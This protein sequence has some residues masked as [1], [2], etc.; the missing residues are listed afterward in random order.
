[1]TKPDAIAAIDIG[2]DT[3]HLLIGSVADSEDGPLVNCI[4]QEGQLLLLGDRAAV[5]G[6][7]H[8]R[9]DRQWVRSGWPLHSPT[10][11]SAAGDICPRRHRSLTSVARA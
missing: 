5:K 8:P 6:R 10:I 2:S 9:R 1:M 11:G 4:Q 3:V 7:P